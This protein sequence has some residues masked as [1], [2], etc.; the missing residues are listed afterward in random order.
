MAYELHDACVTHRKCSS[1]IARSL[2]CNFLRL[3]QVSQARLSCFATELSNV[4]EQRISHT[5]LCGFA[6]QSTQSGLCLEVHQDLD[7]NVPYFLVTT[8]KPMSV[9]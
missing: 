6:S 8:C 9:V 5:K 2:T 4:Y 7:P 1:R 3:F